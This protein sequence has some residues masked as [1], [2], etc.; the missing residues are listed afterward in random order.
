VSAI[1]HQEWEACGG[2]PVLHAVSD[3]VSV[4][5]CHDSLMCHADMLLTSSHICTSNAQHAAKQ[6]PTAK[7]ARRNTSCWSPYLP[8]STPRPACPCVC[9]C[10]RV[11]C[12]W[13]AHARPVQHV[14][15]QAGSRRQ[16]SAGGGW[17]T[18]R[19][20]SAHSNAQP[21][22]LLLFSIL[23]FG[24]IPYCFPPFSWR[25]VAC[26]VASGWQ[27]RR[28]AARSASASGADRL[29]GQPTAS[30]M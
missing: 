23:S 17:S 3:G 4:T 6:V 20:V 14:Q 7:P 1:A 22:G 10:R 9:A 5:Q 13:G 8:L 19:R 12:H 18:R 21:C 11:C 16:V 27:P 29:I 28:S 26:L 30:H 24:V 25:G 15:S 2:C